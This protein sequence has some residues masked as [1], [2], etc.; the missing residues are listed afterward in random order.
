MVLHAV[1]REARV[2]VPVGLVDVGD[3]EHIVALVLHHRLHRLVALVPDETVQ[4]VLRYLLLVRYEADH[5]D[6]AALVRVYGLQI[7]SALRAGDLEA[8]LAWKSERER[9]REMRIRLKS[10]KLFDK[11]S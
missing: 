9:E 7:D 1:G 2:H 5:V 6:L 11:S 4:F 10:F 8:W 3:E